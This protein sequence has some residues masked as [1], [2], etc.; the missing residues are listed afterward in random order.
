MANN[1]KEL[2][3]KKRSTRNRRGLAGAAR[4]P[5]SVEGARRPRPTRVPRVQ[6]GQA[7]VLYQY[8]TVPVP[9]DASRRVS[10]CSGGVSHLLAD[11]VGDGVV[12]A[13]AALQ[14]EGLAN[15]GARHGR[16]HFT[17]ARTFACMSPVKSQPVNE[18]AIIYSC[19]CVMRTCI[20]NINIRSRFMMRTSRRIMITL[21]HP[22]RNTQLT[23]AIINV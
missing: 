16:F 14:P 6:S 8:C 15:L 18:S 11:G 23:R 9:V 7:N 4:D 3:V 21:N 2:S 19:I 17:K 22:A 13:D 10:R 1:C 5:V 12:R 20:Y